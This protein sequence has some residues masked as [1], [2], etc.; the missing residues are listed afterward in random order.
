MTIMNKQALEVG[1]DLLQREAMYLD[2]KRWGDWVALFHRDCEYWVPMW[3][4]EEELTGD[5]HGELS[6]MYY[7]SRSGLED[8][9]L[10]IRSRRSPAS[11]PMPR[12]THLVGG[13]VISEPPTAEAI[14]LH[15]SWSC[16][17]FYPREKSQHVFFGHSEYLLEKADGEWC[18]KKK[19]TVLQNDYI[20][21]LLDI[22]CI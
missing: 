21:S 8:R 7:P 4:S 5:P 11:V 13:V 10:R 16:H 15:S 1:I 14:R 17:V 9:V 20:P 22:Y 12:T 19:R 3:R 6:H 2:Q 18:I